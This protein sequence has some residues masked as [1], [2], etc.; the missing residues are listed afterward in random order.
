MREVGSGDYESCFDGGTFCP[1]ETEEI[2][3]P[4]QPKMKMALMTQ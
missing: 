3:V 1:N 4:R 2:L